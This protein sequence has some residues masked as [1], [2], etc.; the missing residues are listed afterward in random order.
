MCSSGFD[1]FGSLG[2]FEQTHFLWSGQSLVCT[3]TKAGSA[4]DK[5]GNAEGMLSP[6]DRNASPSP[7]V[8]MLD[9]AVPLT[10][11]H[12]ILKYQVTL[13]VSRSLYH[14]HTSVCPLIQACQ[15]HRPRVR[16]QGLPA[17]LE[18]DKSHPLIVI[19]RAALFM[20]ITFNHSYYIWRCSVMIHF[21]KGKLTL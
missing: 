15:S 3:M 20:V 16:G 17:R 12:A 21:V 8:T 7:Q 13:C 19:H 2:V 1:S 14:S 10:E 6:L 18:S 11:T 4:G 9:S 5:E